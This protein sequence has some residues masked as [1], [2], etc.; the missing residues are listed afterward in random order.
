MSENYPMRKDCELIHFSKIY[1]E[2][3]GKQIDGMWAD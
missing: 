2:E 1:P 3:T